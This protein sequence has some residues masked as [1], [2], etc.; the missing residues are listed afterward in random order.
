LDAPP[1]GRTWW[2]RNS[3]AVL[4]T[5]SVVMLALVITLQMAC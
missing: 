2:E 1:A 3:A 4:A 5:F